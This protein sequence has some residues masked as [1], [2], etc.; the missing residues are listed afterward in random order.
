MK[1]TF[2]IIGVGP[3]DPELITMKAVRVLNRCNVWMTPS[4][5]RGGDSTALTIARGAVD[6]D[7]KEIIQHHFP[8]KK[9]HRGEEPVEEIKQA[10]KEAAE[11]INAI[12]ESGVSVAFPTLGD[13]AIYCT[14]YYV[15]ETLSQLNPAASVKI[16]PGVSAIC[17]TSATAMTP[18]C[19]G[20]ERLVILPAV[21]EAEKLKDILLQFE[22][23]VLM[24]VHKAMDKLVPLLTELGLL[25]SS[26]LVEQTSMEKELIHHD[27][28]SLVGKELHYFSTLI[29][30]TKKQ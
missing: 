16:I 19:L 11:K 9:I 1:G 14:G 25:E 30:H 7:G 12:L 5:S 10:W 8:M 13:P 3:G 27:L 4:A 23:V 17:A 21:F 18:L 15:Y 26:V 6:L 22:T 24:K 2:Y 29:V 20:D 28:H